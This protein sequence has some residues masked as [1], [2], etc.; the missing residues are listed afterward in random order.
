ME[1][2]IVDSYISAAP[3][4]QAACMRLLLSW[5]EAEVPEVHVQIKWSRPVFGTTHDFAYFKSTKKHLSLGF[6]KGEGLPDPQGLL[7][8]D[9][10][11]MRHIKLNDPATMPETQIR[12]WMRMAANLK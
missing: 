1:L 7:E 10:K 5:L 9:G 11:D 3:A 12:E 4:P 2:T 8:G 6:M